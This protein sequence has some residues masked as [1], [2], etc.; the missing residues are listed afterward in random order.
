MAAPRKETMM[1]TLLVATAAF[2]ALMIG[3]PVGAHAADWNTAKTPTNTDE[4]TQRFNAGI[5]KATSLGIAPETHCGPDDDDKTG[6]HACSTTWV[7]ADKDN[8]GATV[9]IIAT[10]ANGMAGESVCAGSAGEHGVRTCDSSAGREWVERWNGATKTWDETAVKRESWP[11]AQ[12][13]GSAA[14][15]TM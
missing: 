10:F 12:A 1:K 4:F 2:A 11:T 7:R 3:A 9:L 15:P 5:L 6:G 13:T 14:A 8:K